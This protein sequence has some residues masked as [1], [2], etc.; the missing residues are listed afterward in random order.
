MPTLKGSDSLKILVVED[1]FVSRS[2]IQ[3]AVVKLGHECQAAEDGH[4]GWEA[5]QASPFQVIISDWMMP[6]MDG[7]EL[8]R[9]V[10]G[11]KAEEYCYFI[12]LSSLDKRQH[13]LEGLRAGADDYLTKPLEFDELQ[14]R[15]IS[16]DRVT[17]LHRNLL[18]AQLQAAQANKLAA[19]GQLAAGVAHELNTPLGAIRLH[20]EGALR[21]LDNVERVEKKLN[22][23]LRAVDGMRQIV[24]QLLNYSVNAPA[25]EHR[26]DLS[27]VVTDTLGLIKP[28]FKDSVVEVT[29]ELEEGVMVKFSP[30]ELQQV[31]INL[32][33]NARDAVMAE[34]GRGPGITIRVARAGDMGQLQVCDEGSGIADNVLPRIFDPFFSTK[35][36]GSGTGLGLSVSKS[37]V[38]K[39]GGRLSASS[40]PG[41]DTVFKV[42][43][44]LLGDE[45]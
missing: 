37:L 45:A 29:T 3:S 28:Q 6:G 12:I 14:A 26:A 20:L 39:N 7:L 24:S 30:P 11:F 2:V 5:F 19:V 35:A 32:L 36:V 13:V 42:E 4:G 44:P 18:N 43:I 17:S 33:T 41:Q 31:L 40:Q 9:R 21:K 27:T 38:E 10:R 22:S 1:D 15:L 16:A 34:G 25:S 8:C 23:S